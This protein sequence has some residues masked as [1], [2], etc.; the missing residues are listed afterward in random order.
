MQNVR[1]VVIST[2]SPT[3]VRRIFVG[4]RQSRWCGNSGLLLPQR[5]FF[6]RLPIT[7]PKRPTLQCSQCTRSRTVRHCIPIDLDVNDGYIVISCIRACCNQSRVLWATRNQLQFANDNCILES[8]LRLVTCKSLSAILTHQG[9]WCCALGPLEASAWMA[10]S[11]RK[12][13]RKKEDQN[14]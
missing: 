5:L 3:S 13:N 9:M 4:D 12:E 6:N 2:Q 8:S 14:I 10:T 7:N 1:L 11:P